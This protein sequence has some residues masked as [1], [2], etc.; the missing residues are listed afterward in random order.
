MFLHNGEPAPNRKFALLLENGT[1][2]RGE[3][4]AQGRTGLKRRVRP[5]PHRISL[6]GPTPAWTGAS[7]R[8]VQKANTFFDQEFV[9]FLH[10]GEPARNRK[11]ALLRENGTEEQGKSDAQGR[12]GLKLTALEGTHRIRIFGPKR[13]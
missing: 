8:S 5:G 2:E 9:L 6:F 3:S 1:K 11:F 7:V 13:T 4:D 12:T 10:N